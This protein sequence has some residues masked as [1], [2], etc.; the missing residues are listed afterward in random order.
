MTKHRF[1]E[2]AGNELKLPIVKPLR[3]GL[4]KPSISEVVY[5]SRTIFLNAIVIH[6]HEAEVLIHCYPS[7]FR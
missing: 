6:T 4:E 3:K 7:T 1:W 5:N 2:D